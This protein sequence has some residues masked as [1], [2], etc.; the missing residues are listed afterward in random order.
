[1]GIG[2][3]VRA[4]KPGMLGNSAGLIARYD[5]V[6]GTGYASGEEALAH[7]GL[8]PQKAVD[9]EVTWGRHRAARTGVTTD[10]AVNVVVEGAGAGA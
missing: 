5:I 7:L 6:I 4:Y 3:V 10:Q 2:S 8:G 9:L 1:M